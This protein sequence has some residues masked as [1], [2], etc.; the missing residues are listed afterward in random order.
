[1]DFMKLQLCHSVVRNSLYTLHVQVEVN[2]GMTE[3]F[4]ATESNLESGLFQLSQRK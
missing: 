1:M 3:R 4:S 2:D